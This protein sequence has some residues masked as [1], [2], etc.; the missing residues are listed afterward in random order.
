MNI[1]SKLVLLVATVALLNLMQSNSARSISPSSTH[2]TF[3]GNSQGWGKYGSCLLDHNKLFGNNKK[4]SLWISCYEGQQGTWHNHFK[5]IKNGNYRITGQLRTLGI[6]KGGSEHTLWVFHG[7]DHGIQTIFKNNIRGTSNWRKFSFPVTV[8][9]NNFH[10]WFRLK[11]TGQ[12]WLDDIKLERVTG[13]PSSIELG[14]IVTL[15]KGKDPGSGNQCRSCGRWWKRKLKACPVC[16]N[17][18]DDHHHQNASK[19][20]LNS[21]TL[22]DFEEKEQEEEI[23]RYKWNSLS[24]KFS[25]SKKRSAVIY[26]G[27]YNNCDMSTKAMSDWSGYDFLHMD[28]YN[29]LDE[30]MGFALSI[31]DDKSGD[32]WTHLNHYSRLAPGWNKTRFRIKRFVGERGSVKVRR[33]LNLKKL[34]KFWFKVRSDDKRTVK[35]KFYVDNIRLSR[36]KKPALFKGLRAFDFAKDHHSAFPGF[37]PVTTQQ[38]YSRDVGYGF[39]KETVFWRIHDSKY[40]DMLNKDALIVTKGRFFV[41]LP[42]GKYRVLLNINMLGYWDVPFWNKRRVNMQGFPVLNRVRLSARDYLKDFLQFENVHPLPDDN[43]YD[44]YLKKIFKPVDTIVNVENGY[45]D[46]EFEGNETGIALNSLLIWPLNKDKQGRKFL[47]SLHAVLRNDF[48]NEVRRVEPPVSPK[49]LEIISSKDRAKGF[50]TALVAPNKI[51]KYS[52]IVKTT[53]GSIKLRG[54]MEERPYQ[55]I[56]VRNLGKKTSL[57]VEVSDLKSPTGRTIS[58]KNIIL[59]YGVPQF[60]SHTMNHETYELIPRALR[61]FPKK[62]GIEIT[63]DYSLHL[64]YQLPIDSNYAPGKYRGTLTLKMHGRKMPYPVLLEVYPYKLPK[65]D[66]P[67]GF[68]GLNPVTYNWFKAKDVATEMTNWSKKSLKIL[69]ERGFNTWSGLPVGGQSLFKNPSGWK[70]DTPQVDRLFEEARKLGLDQPVFSYGSNFLK[71]LINGSNDNRPGGMSDHQYHTIAASALKDKM[72]SGNWPPIIYTF[73][74]EASGYSNRVDKDIAVGKM[75]AKYF[76]FL[77]RGG[78]SHMV[79]PKKNLSMLNG[80]F[81]DGSYSSFSKDEV[82]KLKKMNLNWGSYGGAG[83]P[84]TNPRFVCG[85]GLYVARRNGLS[86]RLSWHFSNFQNY[87]YYDLDGREYDAVMVFPRSNG[88]LEPSIKLEFATQG[89]EDYRLLVLLEN[90]VNN[91]PKKSKAARK[92]LED[93]YW[94]VD[95]FKN[96]N[97]LLRRTSNRASFTKFRDEITAHILDLF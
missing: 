86:H 39:G 5:K 50:Y 28:V 17:H 94:K 32:Y 41:N 52:S 48:N 35:E 73:S 43:P 59:R 3:D 68:F 72:T 4:G 34:T 88:T 78:F 7:G 80:Y 38:I 65:V 70:L 57:R 27:V 92:W 84:L 91:N 77:R 20:A 81:T 44:L 42:N 90:L 79:P 58:G 71:F 15:P 87:P 19:N 46:I 18:L 61:D 75:L 63:N 93:N 66:F 40:A 74:D 55:T 82:D 22:L 95:F 26:H 11:T 1:L 49:S 14:P 2:F 64:W 12:V 8:T 31:G 97:Y 69:A 96:P 6:H 10:L 37:F 23:K 45:L 54:G 9:E 36:G 89:L 16:G 53:G 24:G 29:P 51:V 21:R 13:R 33:F 83:N 76:P 47:K 62:K 56:M 60:V 30:T 67:V 25:T 85:E